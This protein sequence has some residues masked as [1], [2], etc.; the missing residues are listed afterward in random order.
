VPLLVRLAPRRWVYTGASLAVLAWS[1]AA[2]TLRPKIL[3]DGSTVTFVILGTLVTFSA[4]LLVSQN[5]DLITRPSRP[6]LLRPTHGGLA[7]R[8]AVAYPV[9]RRFRTGAILIMYSLVV[10]TLVL[11]AVLGGLIDATV[12]NEVANASGGFAVRADFNPANPVPDPA[13][14]LTITVLVGVAAIASVLATFWPARQ[15]SPHPP[16]GRPAHRR[17]NRR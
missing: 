15:A 11:I 12:D 7:G 14:W 3:K 16:R 9:A 13:R 2:N 8:L 1:L 17:L 10:F 4:V 5:Q 6:L